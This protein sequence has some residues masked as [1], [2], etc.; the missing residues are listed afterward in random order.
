MVAIVSAMWFD[1][2]M[3]TTWELI[4][5]GTYASA[6]WR[7]V[8]EAR[9][10]QWLVSDRGSVVCSHYSLERAQRWVSGEVIR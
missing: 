3:T 10:G 1:S 7:Y 9:G 8:I 5:E 2:Y 4:A 6:D